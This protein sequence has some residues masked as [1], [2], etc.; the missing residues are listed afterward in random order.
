M[1]PER[2]PQ[3]LRKHTS[4]SGDGADGALGA[5]GLGLAICKGLA[6]AHGGRIRTASGGPGQGTPITF[7][8]S[9]AGEPGGEVTPG[10]G[11]D[12]RAVPGGGRGPV[13]ILVVDDHP[14]ALRFMREALAGTEYV[15]VVTGDPEALTVLLGDPPSVDEDDADP[16]CCVMPLDAVALPGVRRS[17]TGPAGSDGHAR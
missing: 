9:V 14:K 8:L 4:L 5:A 13:P 15:Q 2:L 3:L 17:G 16:Y 10:R 6:E 1:A 12:R 11:A 7:T